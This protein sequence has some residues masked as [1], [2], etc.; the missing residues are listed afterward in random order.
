MNYQPNNFSTFYNETPNQYMGHENYMANNYQPIPNIPMKI[1][2]PMSFQESLHGSHHNSHSSQKIKLNPMDFSYLQS[3]DNIKIEQQNDRKDKH[4]EHKQ[5]RE[6]KEYKEQKVQRNQK[7]QKDLK[8]QQREQREREL[9][10][11]ELREFKELKQLQEQKEKELKELKELKE[12]KD[13][14][15]QKEQQNEKDYAYLK[16][17]K[18]HKASHSKHPNTSH[19][20][21][22]VAKSRA[23]KNVEKKTHTP[24]QETQNI[25]PMMQQ[26]NSN[27]ERNEKREPS[28]LSKGMSF[29]GN[30]GIIKGEPLPAYSHQQ[31]FSIVPLEKDM[32]QQQNNRRSV[33]IPQIYQTQPSYRPNSNYFYGP[34]QENNYINNNVISNNFCFQTGN[35]NHFVGV[36][37]PNVQKIT[38]TKPNG[39]PPATYGVMELNNNDNFNNQYAINNMNDRTYDQKHRSADYWKSSYYPYNSQN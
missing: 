35:P 12:M 23:K 19:K 15:E 20:E 24:S 13:R 30:P 37:Y 16:G 22:K 39:Y 25:K 29:S 28:L 9:K 14:K 17:H 2:K 34:P 36:N 26:P 10:E 21:K 27:F 6:Q 31:Y 11:K 7:M 8:E 33:Q 18:D 1:E 4:K 3:E 5:H 32:Q 38:F